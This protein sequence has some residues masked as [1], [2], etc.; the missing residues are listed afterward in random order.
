MYFFALRRNGYGKS[1]SKSSDFLSKL[2]K[3]IMSPLALDAIAKSGEQDALI[4]CQG[5]RV[6]C[7]MLNLRFWSE[8][9]TW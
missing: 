9:F 8:I 5:N 6:K 4:E 1:K 3:Q 7:H 2:S